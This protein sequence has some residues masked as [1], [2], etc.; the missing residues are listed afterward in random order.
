MREIFTCPVCGDG[1]TCEEKRWLCPRGHSFDRAAEGYVHLLTPAQMRSKIPGDPPEMVR[2]RRD[3]LA[4]GNYDFLADALAELLQSSLP[5]PAVLF[6]AGCGEGHYTRRIVETLAA[7]DREVMPAGVDI[8]KTAVRMAAKKVPAGRFA[9]ASLYHLPVADT[10]VDAVLNIFSPLCEGELSRILRPGGRMY[11]VVPAARHLFEMKE[12]L[13][14][15]PY[16]NEEKDVEYAGFKLIGTEC[17][18]RRM[19]LSAATLGNLFAMTPY[20]WRSPRE[21]AEALQK[22][23]ALSVT[24][25]FRICI[26][27]KA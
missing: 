13:Y 9:V 1:L 5:D 8:A 21:G 7:A 3:F 6:D 25:A 26:Y 27:E 20:F 14:P 23:E 22:M 11:Y 18:S 2:A 16:E 17:I 4:S 12:I 15:E 19:E 24:A 10:S